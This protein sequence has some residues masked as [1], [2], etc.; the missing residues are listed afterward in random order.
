MPK[1]NSGIKRGKTPDVTYHVN[2]TYN[3]EHDGNGMV[4]NVNIKIDNEP[5]RK[6]YEASAGTRITVN[7]AGLGSEGTGHYV[8]GE[9]GGG[10]KVLEVF[11]TDGV[12]KASYVLRSVSD[13]KRHFHGAWD[14]T[15]HGRDMR[16]EAR[17]RRRQEKELWK[18]MQASWEKRQKSK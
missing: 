15:I 13:V 14:I 10:Q 1:G 18:N 12:R 16:A 9:R 4:R 6:V 11:N 3:V 2:K 5:F 17:E 7:Y 8:I